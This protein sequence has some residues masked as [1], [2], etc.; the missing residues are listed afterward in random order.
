MKKIYYVLFAFLFLISCASKNINSEKKI[1]IAKK[2]Q[3]V[4]E[5][6]YKSGQYTTALKKLLEAYETIPND[7]D[8][9]N[10]LGLV[11]L[12]KQKYKLAE[13]HFKTALKI[14]PDYIHAKN[15]LGATYLKQ[16]KWDLAIKCF[17]QVADNV[18]YATPEIPLSNLGLVYMHQKMY[19]LAK[20]YFKKA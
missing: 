15:H 8:L 4:G 14:R 18:L 13:Q 17:K 2:I 20:S 1:E 7:P 11:Y 9:H 3:Y 16:K 10:S 19:K 5:A 6:H 12:A